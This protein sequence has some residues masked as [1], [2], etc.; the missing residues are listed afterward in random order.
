MATTDVLQPVALL[1]AVVAL[2]RPADLVGDVRRGCASSRSGRPLREVD[3]QLGGRLRVGHGPVRGGVVAA[4]HEP[5][6]V[7]ELPGAGIGVQLVG[8]ARACRTRRSASSSASFGRWRS[9]NGRSKAT[10]CATTGASP[11]HSAKLASTSDAVGALATSSSLMP[12]IWWPMIERP[13]LTSDS[14]RSTTSPPRTLER[15]DVDDVAVLRLHGGRLE[16]EHHELGVPSAR[17]LPSFTTESALGP[18]NGSFLALPAVAT[19]FSCRSM[20]FCSS[21]WP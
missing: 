5:H 16:V 18:R 15:G 3:E 17:R 14:K 6:E 9:T 19:S 13:G 11:T 7:G 1:G 10:L 12:W 4:E 2:A 20:L 21:C 8:R